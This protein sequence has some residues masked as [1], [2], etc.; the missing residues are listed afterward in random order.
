MTVDVTRDSGRATAE[1]NSIE[2]ALEFQ[3]LQVGSVHGLLDGW[4]FQIENVGFELRE[5]VRFM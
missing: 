2:T 4:I 5:C 3:H 1:S